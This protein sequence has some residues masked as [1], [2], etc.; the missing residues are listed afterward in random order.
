MLLLLHGRLWYLPLWLPL[1]CR[2]SK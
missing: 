2:P 1:W